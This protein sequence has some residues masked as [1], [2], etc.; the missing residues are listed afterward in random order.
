MISPSEFN[1]VVGRSRPNST[2]VEI[3]DQARLYVREK[4]HGTFL[5]SYAELGQ[6]AAYQVVREE[7]AQALAAG[8][9]EAT[10]VAC[11]RWCR[12]VITW[13]KDHPV[14]MMSP[15]PQRS[16]PVPSCSTCGETFLLAN[17]DGL[18]CPLHPKVVI[19]KYREERPA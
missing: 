15:S 12:E 16:D 13:T 19:A 14:L 5:P 7:I 11:R 4:L 6:S 9:L 8:D 1:T 10:K 17:T 3:L 2:C 18:Y